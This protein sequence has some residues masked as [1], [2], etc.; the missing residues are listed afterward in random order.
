MRE[1]TAHSGGIIDC[2]WCETHVDGPCPECASLRHRA[3]RLREDMDTARIARELSITPERTARLLAQA[4]LEDALAQLQMGA[5]TVPVK[6]LRSLW[7]RR[8]AED[9][10]LT[11]AGLAREVQMARIDLRRALGKSPAKARDG[12]EAK[13]QQQVTL[14]TAERIAG[15]LGVAPAD[16]ARM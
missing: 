3:S 13:A 14:P 16:I 8:R 11:E 4:D 10:E 6:T 7:E 9:F 5:A 1:D 12:R 2:G 15:A